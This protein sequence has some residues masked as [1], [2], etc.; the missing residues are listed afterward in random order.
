[1][2]LSTFHLISIASVVLLAILLML[3]L[4]E[5]SL[6]YRVN[7]SRA[8]LDSQEFL[9]YLSAIIDAPIRGHSSVEVLDPVY[10]WL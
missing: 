5:P 2:E 6:P 10:R 9:G 8:A 3:V 4:F 7:A 1:M